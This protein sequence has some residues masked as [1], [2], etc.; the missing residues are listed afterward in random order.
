MADPRM[1][2]ELER[3]WAELPPIEHD[4][5]P[6]PSDI[7]DDDDDKPRMSDTKCQDLMVIALLPGRPAI[8]SQ[9]DVEF[10]MGDNLRDLVYEA[11]RIHFMGTDKDTIV[12]AYDVTK[13][14]RA[15]FAEGWVTGDDHQMCGKDNIQPNVNDVAVQ[16]GLFSKS[17][18]AVST[19]AVIPPRPKANST[20]IHPAPAKAASGK[21]M[22]RHPATNHKV[23][24]AALKRTVEAHSS[25]REAKAPVYVGCME[26]MEAGMA[27]FAFYDSKHRL[28]PRAAQN[29]V[30]LHAWTKSLNQAKGK[31]MLLHDK[32]K[33]SRGREYNLRAAVYLARNRLTHWANG[34]DP[35][36]RPLGEDKDL[37]VPYTLM[38]NLAYPDQSVMARCKS[39]EVLPL[40][41]GMDHIFI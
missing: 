31:S 15:V 27:V 19:G 14:L 25:A 40:W 35:S 39:A 28:L 17:I 13:L 37:F 12:T 22:R 10:A 11:K 38:R 5:S 18:G 2:D 6:A 26:G 4:S 34:N 8:Q 21:K 41:Q 20:P 29:Y 30:K 36:T 24:K 23:A 1:G 7:D 9:Q 3:R 33:M 32:F 16:V